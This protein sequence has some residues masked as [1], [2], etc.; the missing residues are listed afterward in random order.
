MPA[1]PWY[2]VVPRVWALG[3]FNRLMLQLGIPRT[4]TVWLQVVLHPPDSIG[5]LM[6]TVNV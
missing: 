5:R 6:E 2:R 1:G 4:S 3:S